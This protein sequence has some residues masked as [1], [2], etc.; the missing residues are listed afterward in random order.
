MASPA[1]ANRMAAFGTP[2][3]ALGSEHGEVFRKVMFEG[4]ITNINF[5][6]FPSPESLFNFDF[7]DLGQTG[8]AHQ[9]LAPPRN[10]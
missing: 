3:F 1:L 4:Q 7:I 8:S 9:C 10:C 6:K 5:V 2:T